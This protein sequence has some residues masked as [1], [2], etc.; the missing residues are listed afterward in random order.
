M[1]VKDWAI[2]AFG[3]DD[4]VVLLGGILVLL[5]LFAAAVGLAARR[6]RR[7]GVAGVLVFGVIGAAAALSRPGSGWPD[8]LPSAAGAPAG[9]GV[10]WLLVGRLTGAGPG[11][12]V[13]RDRAALD[14]RGFVLAAGAS[15]AVSAGAGFAGRRLSAS[16]AA[17]AEA[18]RAAVRLPR[19]SSPARPIPARARPR[20]EGLSPF[21]TPDRDFYRVDTALVV[22]RVD[23]G[24]WRLTVHGKGVRR[25]LELDFA[26]LLRRDM[27]ERDITL[28]CVSNEVGG[29]YVSSARW[30]GVPLA[31]FW[32]R[33]GSV[34]RPGAAPPT[35]WSPARST[36]WPSAPRSTPSWTA[37][38]RSSRSA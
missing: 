19:P 32:R 1:E 7:A 36:A 16:G 26:Q 28:T 29:P 14:R 23:A 18:S 4:K 15:V 21:T 2:R 24:S 25:P 6:N 3:E 22:P 9:A 38:T 37:G 8:A 33:P 31:P 35:S 5:T 20:V 17:D 12:E 10:L 34:R 30:L 11:T 13:S 27:I